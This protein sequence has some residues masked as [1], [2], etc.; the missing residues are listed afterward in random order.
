MEPF[1]LSAKERN[2]SSMSM[3][4]HVEKERTLFEKNKNPPLSKSRIKNLINKNLPI[5]EISN[6]PVQDGF[7]GEII[8]FFKTL[9]NYEY[10]K[11]LLKVSYNGE[12]FEAYYGETIYELGGAIDLGVK[13]SILGN[14]LS[15]DTCSGTIRFITSESTIEDCK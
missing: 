6:G 2:M 13:A 4:K 9:N 14:Y 8:S 5:V 15:S 7:N 10:T 1:L 3:K 12:L 11:S